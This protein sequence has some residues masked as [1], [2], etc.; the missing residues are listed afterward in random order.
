MKKKANPRFR[1]LLR[2]VVLI[3]I[4]TIIGLVVKRFWPEGE[5]PVLVLQDSQQA[6]K[7]EHVVQQN[8]QDSPG[9]VQ[10]N[11]E[12][13][14]GGTQVAIG[15]ADQVTFN[16][17]PGPRTISAE[18][19][20]A[21]LGHLKKREPATI[22][23]RSVL[24]DQESLALSTQIAEVFEKADWKVNKVQWS[25]SKPFKDIV[26]ERRLPGPHTEI[27]YAVRDL[28]NYFG[29]TPTLYK[30]KDLKPNRYRLTV[31]SQ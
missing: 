23:I 5:S 20:E 6:T 19:A 16:T 24:G 11:M 3:I 27:Q 21:I 31:G 18:L 30:N 9:G 15:H 28:L 1:W 4:A 26:F 7:S 8:M 22:E 10:Q 25:Y 17:S 2:G 14:P 29:H 12:K 13:S